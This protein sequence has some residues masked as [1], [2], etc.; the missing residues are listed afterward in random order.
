MSKDELMELIEELT[1]LF[2]LNA[3]NSLNF[4]SMGGI[5]E[6]MFLVYLQS[7]IPIR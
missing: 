7:E 5:P 1:E 2:E 3:R 6:L 4:C